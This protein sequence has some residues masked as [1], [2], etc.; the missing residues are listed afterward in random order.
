M[1]LIRKA[2][3]P[4][5][6]ARLR[7][8]LTITFEVQHAWKRDPVGGPPAAVRNEVV[9]LCGA[10]GGARAREVIAATDETGICRAGVVRGEGRV[11]VCGSFGGFDIDEAEASGVVGGGEVNAGLPVGDVEALYCGLGCSG[12]QREE[13][14]DFHGGIF[15][16]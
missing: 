6:H 12:Q 3:N 15:E 5:H 7:E 16:W 1:V 10:A 2:R 8:P 13:C 14:C 9:G 11:L 4:A